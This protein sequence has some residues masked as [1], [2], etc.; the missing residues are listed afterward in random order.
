VARAY[1]ISKLSWIRTQQEKLRNQAR[2]TPR[3]FIDRES[4]YLWGRRHLLAVVR[5]EVKPFVSVDHRRITLT[6][7][8]GSDVSKRG[9]VLHEW[10]LPSAVP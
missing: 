4:H 10:S 5:D 9:E 1:A 2:E 7:R 8:R 6:V 3:R